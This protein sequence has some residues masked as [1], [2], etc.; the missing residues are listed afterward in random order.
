MM[1]QS[2]FDKILAYQEGTLS[3]AEKASFEA[4][5][6][7]NSALQEA[8]QTFQENIELTDVLAYDFMREKLKSWNEPQ[9]KRFNLG[10]TIAMAASFL[11]LISLIGLWRINYRFN[12][13]ELVARYYIEIPI[14]T[15]ARNGNQKIDTVLNQA[16]K[17][18][19]TGNYQEILE[20]PL[21][22]DPRLNLLKGKAAIKSKQPSQAFLY[23]NPIIQ[24]NQIPYVEAAEWL[25]II[26]KLQLEQDVINE[27]DQL[28]EN[29]NHA[30]R[31][32]AVK[33]RAD[34]NTFWRRF[35]H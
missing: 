3:D 12:N 35:T 29:R 5:L 4:E 20:G 17:D 1:N 18:Y 27:L 9:A 6:K 2:Y 23:L 21:I 34:L 14:S 25:Y 28:I 8:Y 24:L 32:D 26:A 19:E 11:I 10:R 30:F 15:T 16:N 31:E 7:T 13:Q 33:L 22:G